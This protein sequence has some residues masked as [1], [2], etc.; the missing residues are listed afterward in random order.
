MDVSHLTLSLIHI[1]RSRRR[2]ES[3]YRWSPY[4]KKNFC[5]EEKGNMA[6]WVALA[7]LSFGVC[8]QPDHGR[9]RGRDWTFGKFLSYGDQRL[10]GYLLDTGV[11]RE[12][13]WPLSWFIF[14]WLCSRCCYHGGF[15]LLLPETWSLPNTVKP[16]TAT[17]AWSRLRMIQRWT[18]AR[19]GVLNLWVLTPLRIESPFH[20]SHISCISEIYVLIHNSS[21]VTV[22]K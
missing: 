1:W 2:R 14:D 3:R 17:F 4:Q 11:V 10:L 12:N 19:A 18:N 6:S 20:E 22:M 5:G 13:T 21:K 8:C 7:S 15:R 16:S 9:R